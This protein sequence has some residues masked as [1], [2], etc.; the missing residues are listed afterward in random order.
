VRKLYGLTV[1]L[2]DKLL[3]YQLGACAGCG[4]RRVYRLNV[5]HDHETGLVR[6]LLCRRCNKVLRD[7]RDDINILGRLRL[8]LMSPPAQELGIV[9]RAT[10]P[11]ST[12]PAD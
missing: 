1:E 8:Y 5:D 4:Q 3:E 6:G 2:W 7:V 10:S 9:A 11:E 12:P